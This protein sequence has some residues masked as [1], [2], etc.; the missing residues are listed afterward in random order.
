MLPLK[1][2][3]EK[4]NSFSKSLTFVEFSIG[5]LSLKM[6]Y[7]WIWML[8]LSR[9]TRPFAAALRD[10]A[11]GLSSISM[12]YQYRTNTPSLRR[13]VSTWTSSLP[14]IHTNEDISV[15]FRICCILKQVQ[16]ISQSVKNMYREKKECNVGQ[17]FTFM[18]ILFKMWSTSHYSPSI[19]RVL[20]CF[21]LISLGEK[22]VSEPDD[23]HYVLKVKIELKKIK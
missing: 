14:W 20:C 4:V 17:I 11:G 18:F 3:A 22:N 16:W 9:D 15:K 23:S 1:Y 7:R 6:H 19:I 10:P 5:K 2:D 12:G 13:Y 8:L 21:M